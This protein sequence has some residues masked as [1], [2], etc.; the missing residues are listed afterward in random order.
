MDDDEGE[1][2][3][4][5]LN[6][7]E[8]KFKN[9]NG[10]LLLRELFWETC[11]N[12]ENA[13]YTLKDTDYMGLPSLYRLYMEEGD[14]TEYLFATKHLDSWAHWE[15]LSSAPFFQTYVTR[16]RTELELRTRAESL[17]TIIKLAKGGGREALQAS[18]YITDRGYSKEGKGRPSKE[19]ISEAAHD[20]AE[21]RRRVEEDFLRIVK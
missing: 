12:K 19:A 7:D 16:W 21:S 5:D 6:V 10:V 4:L 14:L 13:V 15:A 17:A 8:S 11:G 2:M 20:I 18:K 1:K 9:T 3:A